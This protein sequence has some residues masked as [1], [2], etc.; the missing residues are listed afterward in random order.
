MQLCWVGSPFKN[1]LIK[2]EIIY[3]FENVKTSLKFI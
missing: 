1:I 3:N 2:I